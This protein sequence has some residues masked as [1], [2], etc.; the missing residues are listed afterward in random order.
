M[1]YVTALL[2]VLIYTTTNT[3]TLSVVNSLDGCY[4]L[5]IIEVVS[6]RLKL[7]SMDE[8][9]SLKV[10]EGFRATTY[11]IGYERTIGYGCLNKYWWQADTISVEQAD[12]LL[13]HVYKVFEKN[14]LKH[15]PKASK[16]EIA[17]ITHMYFWLGPGNARPFLKGDSLHRKAFAHK[18]RDS[19]GLKTRTNYILRRFESL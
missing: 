19:L 11:D 16:A 14:A 3:A 1:K 9:D 13:R 2:L 8:I 18:Y 12:S 7:A 5:P 4:E 10:Y 6:D 17:L 15:H